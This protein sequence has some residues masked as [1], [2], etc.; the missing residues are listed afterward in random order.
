MSE[1]DDTDRDLDKLVERLPDILRDE[2]VVI[3]KHS[4]QQICIVGMLIGSATA[5]LIVG[6]AFDISGLKWVWP[7]VI[8]GLMLATKLW[9]WWRGDR[10]MEQLRL[11]NTKEGVQLADAADAD[12]PRR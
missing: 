2:W 12:S 5:L 9:P 8:V 10:Y 1:D 11:A 3:P 6:V 4:V 7:L